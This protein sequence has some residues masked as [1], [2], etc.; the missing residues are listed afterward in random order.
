MACQHQKQLA[1][2]QAIHADAKT[3]DARAEAAD[4]IAIYKANILRGGW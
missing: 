2:W 4:H 1:L 3:A